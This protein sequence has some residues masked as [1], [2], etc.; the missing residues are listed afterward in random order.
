[1]PT[2][3]T[4]PAQSNSC[5]ASPAA[6]SQENLPE[7]VTLHWSP[8]HPPSTCTERT[9]LSAVTHAWTSFALMY[10]PSQKI[11]PV[12]PVHCV[13]HVLDSSLRQVSKLDSWQL[14]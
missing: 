4:P 8:E 2:R 10:C 12:E 9:P 6:V 11:A 3:P 13:S 5:D 14:S 7:A 1:M